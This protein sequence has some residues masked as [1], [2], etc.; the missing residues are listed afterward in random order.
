MYFSKHHPGLVLIDRGMGNL[1]FRGD[2]ILRREDTE[3]YNHTEP[4]WKE[5]FTSLTVYSGITEI[6]D[7]VIQQFPGVGKLILPDSLTRIEMSDGLSAF[8]HANDVLV[9][10]SFGTCGCR[11]A[12]DGGLRFLPE[13]I[14]LGWYRDEE[15][16][17]ST[18]LILRF[19]EDGSMDLLY[20]IFT[21]GIS[22]GSSGGASLEREMPEEYSPG[23]TPEEFAGLFPACYHNQIMQNPAVKLFLEWDAAR[24][25]QQMN[26][27]Q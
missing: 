19:H 9:C 12:C 14:E 8:L 1:E 18:M 3:V 11:F 4:D 24:A 20:D 10:A 2:G 16:D 25:E 6:C 23:C 22:A 26:N 15:H 5:A 17:E 27:R 7:G 21:A 13:D